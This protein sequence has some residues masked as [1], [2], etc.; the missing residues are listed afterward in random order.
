MFSYKE[1]IFITGATG[2]IAHSL[3]RN[4]LSNPDISITLYIQSFTKIRRLYCD[5]PRFN[6]P[7]KVNV[8]QGNFINEQPFTDAIVG[9]TR[10]FLYVPVSGYQNDEHMEFGKCFAQKAYAVGVQQIVLISNLSWPVPYKLFLAINSVTWRLEEAI[11]SIP[12]R[13]QLV[14]LRPCYLMSNMFHMDVPTIKSNKAIVSI[15]NPDQVIAWVSPKDVGDVAA[16]FLQ[17]TID[18]NN[19][20]NDIIYELIGDF[21]THKKRAE[22]LSRVLDC[23]IF[24]K[25]TTLKRYYS[26]LTNYVGLSYRITLMVLELQN[27]LKR[28]TRTSVKELSKLLGHQPQTVEEWIKENKYALLYHISSWN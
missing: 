22:I 7:G 12:N 2:V 8:I 28:N 13:K 10:L 27:K 24:Y 11:R 15:H 3:V 23:D 1:K 14:T 9:H 20:D 4:L 16:K 26:L 6:D 21:Q 5:H 19:N 17:E 18:N 25:N